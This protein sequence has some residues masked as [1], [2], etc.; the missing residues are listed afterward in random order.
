LYCV[1]RQKH[2]YCAEKWQ[3]VSL[4]DSDNY[5]RGAAIFETEDEAIS[6]MKIYEQKLQ[7]RN[8]QNHGNNRN[9]RINIILKIFQQ[10]EK[11]VMVQPSFYRR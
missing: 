3:D 4:I 6:Y 8:E 9:N 11:P 1:L 10:E 5:F 7:A 2:R